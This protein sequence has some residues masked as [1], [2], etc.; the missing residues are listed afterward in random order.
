MHGRFLEPGV[1]LQ[2]KHGGTGEIRSSEGCFN[3]GLSSGLCHVVRQD[4]QQIVT[5]EH[6]G[7][8]GAEG[9]PNG[10]AVYRD[11]MR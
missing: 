6:T 3:Q 2:R 10:F 7:Y 1:F 8:F 9:L 5:M 11:K 4:E